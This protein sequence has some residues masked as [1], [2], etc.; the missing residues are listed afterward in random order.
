[1][2]TECADSSCNESHQSPIAECLYAKY[3]VVIYCVLSLLVCKIPINTILVS[4]FIYQIVSYPSFTVEI[5]KKTVSR[6]RTYSYFFGVSV[7][8]RCPHRKAENSPLE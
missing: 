1:M 4:C 7:C 8:E 6:K 3:S 2:E 5:S